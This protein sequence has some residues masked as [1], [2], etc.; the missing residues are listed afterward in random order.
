[1]NHTLTDSDR[2]FLA[3]CGIADPGPLAAAKASDRFT[4]DDIFRVLDTLEFVHERF[5][6]LGPIGKKIVRKALYRR[7]WRDEID[8]FDGCDVL[9]RIVGDTEE[10]KP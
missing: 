6:G 8:P 7:F 9:P 5:N 10:Q 3:D 1:M 4:Q 2:K